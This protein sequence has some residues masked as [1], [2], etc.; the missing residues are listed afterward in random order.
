MV[1]CG[2]VVV[3]SRHGRVN[4]PTHIFSS[5]IGMTFVVWSVQRIPT[6]VKVGFPDRNSNKQ[7]SFFFFFW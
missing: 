3:V 6:A 7:I 2:I 5:D 4:I 1:N